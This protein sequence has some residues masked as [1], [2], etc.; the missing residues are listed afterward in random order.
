MMNKKILLRKK[1]IF[2]ITDITETYELYDS[3]YK[4]CL[5]IKGT[6]VVL[7]G[8]ITTLVIPKN[9]ALKRIY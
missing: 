4:K 3:N 8:R 1:Y 7:D 6:S 9:K 2:Y 5:H